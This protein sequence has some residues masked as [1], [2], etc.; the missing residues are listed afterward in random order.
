MPKASSSR[1]KLFRNSSVNSVMTPLNKMIWVVE[2]ILG[3][4]ASGGLV[5]HAPSWM[6][7]CF[8]CFMGFILLLYGGAYVFFMIKDPSRL[9]TEKYNLEQQEM[10]YMYSRREG[11]HENTILTI[12]KKDPIGVTHVEE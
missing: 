5:L 8:M 7:I 2:L 3:S 6:L 12:P 1:S 10:G 11:M 9:Q 4:C